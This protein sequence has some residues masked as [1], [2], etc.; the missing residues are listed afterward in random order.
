MAISTGLGIGRV[1]RAVGYKLKKANFNPNTPYLP[2]RIAILGEAND[3]NQTGLT[4]APYEF[5]SA[6]EVGDK[7]G[8]GSPLY[9]IARIL[10]PVSGDILGG[11]PTIIYPQVS[12]GGATATVVK[13]SITGTATGNATHTLV[14]NGRDNI[15]G[16]RYDYSVVTGDD[17]AAIIPKIV[18]AVAA[19]LGSP[20][21]ATLNVSDVDFTSKWKGVT[22]AD[23]DIQ[24]ET[25]NKDVGLTY[26]EVSNTAGTGVTDI[27]TSLGLFAEN[28]NTLVISGYT[29][30]EFATYETHNGTPDPDSPT[31]RYVASAFKPYQVFTGLAESDKD[32]IATITDA[33]ARKDQVTNVVAPCPNSK[34]WVFEAAANMV[35]TYAAIAQNSP[36]LDNSGKTYPDMP[37]PSD[38]NIGDFSDYEARDF[39]VKKGSSTVSLKAGKYEVQDMVTTYHPDGETPPKFRFTRDLVVDWNI[40]FG[41]IL[42]MQRDIQDKAIVSDQDTVT[43]SNTISPRQANQLVRSF[44][45]DK[46]AQALLVDVSF[47]NASILVE[48]NSGNPAR[49]DVFFRYKRSSTAHI[50]STDVEVDFAFSL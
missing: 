6:K 9:H 47:T 33:A 38:E 10:R 16:V 29:T 46:A 50:V 7:Y 25:N 31:G 42:I 19:V 1:S 36:H 40:A 2:Q 15:E 20:C 26:A 24:F 30:T 12:D 41:W 5:I 39:L 21:I 34:G 45:K 8:Y 49:L 4:T 13:K 18:A 3:A 14:I 37:I 22:S 44:V 17:A 43:V 48:V 23:L 11:I 27:A 28:W 32:N 35:A